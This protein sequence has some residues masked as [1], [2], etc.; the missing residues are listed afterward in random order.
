MPTVVL[1]INV[2]SRTRTVSDHQSKPEQHGSVLIF[3]NNIMLPLSAD[4]LLCHITIQLLIL[5]GSFSVHNL[6]MCLQSIP[7]M[8]T[9]TKN[10]TQEQK[11]GTYVNI[12]AGSLSNAAAKPV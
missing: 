2:H 1:S 5:A 12:R 8:L 6:V 9:G 4:D 10:M 3:P 7:P 11:E